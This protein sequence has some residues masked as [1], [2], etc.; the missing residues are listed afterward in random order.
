MCDGPWKVFANGSCSLS[1]ERFDYARVLIATT[2]LD[3]VDVTEKIIVDGET[4]EI[5]FLEE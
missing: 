2:S 5:I 4:V 3:V 1:R